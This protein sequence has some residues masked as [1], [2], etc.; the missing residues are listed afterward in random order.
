MMAGGPPTKDPVGC[1]NGRSIATGGRTEECALAGC[2]LTLVGTTEIPL[3]GAFPAGRINDATCRWLP[4]QVVSTII[5]HLSE[6]AELRLLFQT[7]L[8]RVSIDAEGS[9]KCAPASDAGSDEGRISARHLTSV[10]ICC[11]LPMIVFFCGGLVDTRRDLLRRREEK[12]REEQME[13]ENEAI[14]EQAKVKF[15]ELDTNSTGYLE[16]TELVLLAEYVKGI[17]PREGSKPEGDNEQ[18]GDKVAEAVRKLCGDDAEVSWEEFKE[19]FTAMKQSGWEHDPLRK[20]KKRDAAAP[21]SSGQAV[22]IME[23]L[24]HMEKRLKSTES[25]VADLAKRSAQ[26]HSGVRRCTQ[27]TREPSRDS[28]TSRVLTRPFPEKDSPRM[29]PMMGAP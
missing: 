1:D 17:I 18:G 5:T 23:L 24:L 27:F 2:K 6:Q 26:V 29:S 21:C 4:L 25:Q 22:S 13:K 14:L 28:L 11:C 15:E 16:G 19:W 8:S 3:S 20:M 12:E 9:A 7:Q 10:V